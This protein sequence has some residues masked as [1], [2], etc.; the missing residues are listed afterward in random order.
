MTPGEGL[1]PSRQL[2][3]V[4]F[5]IAAAGML[6]STYLT[7]AH[8]QVSALVCTT[9]GIVDCG[10]VT[11]SSYSVVAGIPLALGGLAWFAVSAALALTPL[12]LH[13]EPGW[14]KPAHVA[15]GLVGLVFALY[16]VWVELVVVHRVCEWCTAT[17]ILVLLTVVVALRRLQE[18]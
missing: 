6:I 5:C 17:H 1:T 11:S 16:L 13:A 15:W 4:L 8:Y 9:G 2:P 10:A 12:R 14:L 3:V 18:A 7:F